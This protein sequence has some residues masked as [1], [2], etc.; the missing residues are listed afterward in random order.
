[1]TEP[2]RVD[3]GLLEQTAAR[4]GAIATSLGNT[5]AGSALRDAAAPLAGLDTALACQQVSDTVERQ[6][7]R[8]GDALS[9]YA[10][11][12]G[13]AAAAYRRGD[14]EAADRIQGVLPG[15]QPPEDQ[16]GDGGADP[17]YH[18]VS[19]EDLRRIVPELSEQRAAEIVGPLN[20]AMREG[21]MN[22]P[23]RQAAFI[24]QVA[25]ESDRFRTFEEYASGAAY[26]GRADLGNTQP[27]DG[28]RY[29]GRGAIQ[30]TGRHNY[31]KMSEELGVDFVNHPELA[32]TP[33]YAFKS[34]LWYWNSR[35]GNA[36]ADRGDIVRIT[37]MVNGGHHNLAERT[38]YYNRGLQVLSR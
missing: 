14:T 18:P 7:R 38:D 22:T 1:M 35:D 25:V 4:M 20:D 32:A 5:A 23:Q 29:K 24:S 3:P 11:D 30:V 31:T 28:V 34:A 10:E 16:P 21:G 27:G 8:L 36:F 2:L 12:L 15:D 17:G 9:R 6:A 33:Q 37:E 13:G 19:A 26:E